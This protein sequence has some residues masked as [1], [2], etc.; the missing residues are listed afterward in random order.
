M[1]KVL[2]V[3]DSVDALKSLEF[4]LSCQKY[5]VFIAMNGKDALDIIKR[6]NVDCALVDLFLP[7]Y[8]GWE[9]IDKIEEQKLKTKV[10]V[11]SGYSDIE[12]PSQHKTV[13]ILKKPYDIKDVLAL[14]E[15][16]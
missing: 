11:I 10:I 15:S 12:P 8:N 2:I 7:D 13:P 3:E 5:E 4:I 16:Q 9:L 14:I 1:T 6:E